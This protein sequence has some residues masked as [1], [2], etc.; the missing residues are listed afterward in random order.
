MAIFANRVT[1]TSKITGIISEDCTHAGYTIVVK[2]TS[3]SKSVFLGGERVTAASGF[4]L[5]RGA[6]VSI[7][8]APDDQL[9]GITEAGA[10]VVV[11]YMVT[12]R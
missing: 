9:Y 4:E 12:I 1:V 2:N 6:T 11:H 5:D 3:N 8:V 7:P 10:S